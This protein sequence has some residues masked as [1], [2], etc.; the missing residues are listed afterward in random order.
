MAER[1]AELF[2]FLDRLNNPE[3]EAANRATRERYREAHIRRMPV[4]DQAAARELSAY[5]EDEK[6][7]HELSQ[8]AQDMY[9]KT[10]KKVDRFMEEKGIGSTHN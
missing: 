6:E 9:H 7:L 5:F 2:K 8:A 10:M 4:A 3:Q 1:N